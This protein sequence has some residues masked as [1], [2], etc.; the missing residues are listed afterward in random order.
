MEVAKVMENCVASFN[1][2]S[3]KSMTGHQDINS[4]L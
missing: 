3:P 1:A 4:F 2:E